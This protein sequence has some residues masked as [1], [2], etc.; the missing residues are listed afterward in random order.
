MKLYIKLTFTFF[1]IWGFSN[2][3][4]QTGNI[5]GTVIEKETRQPLAGANVIIIGTDLGASTDVNGKYEINNVPVDIYQIK[6]S[7]VGFESKIETD[8]VVKSNKTIFVNAELVAGSIEGEDIEV[9]STYFEK[10]DDSPISSQS[11]NKEEIRRSPGSREDVSRMLQ[12]FPG[13]NTS[14]DDRND[15]IIRGGSPTEVQFLL[16]NIEIPNPNHFGTQGAT[17]GPIGMINTEFIEKVNFYSGGFTAG[18][19]SKLSGVMDIKL[20]NGN[21][22]RWGGKIDLNFGGAGGY[23]EGPFANRKGSYLVGVHKSFLD[24]LKDALDMDGVPDYTNLQGKINYNFNNTH[25]LTLLWLG[26]D[27][28]IFFD[29]DVDADDFET[30]KI[31]TNYYDNTDFKTR[32]ITGGINLRSIWNNNLY[33]NLTASHTYSSFKLDVHGI[34]VIGINNSGE[35]ENKQEINYRLSFSNS[36]VEQITNLKFDANYIISQNSTL[37]LGGFIKRNMFDHNIKNIPPEPDE[38]DKY[39]QLP[40]SWD[41]NYSY[42]PVYKYGGYINLKF[43]LLNLININA[44]G[45]V[46]HFELIDE[47]SFSPRFTLLIDLTNKLSFHTGYGIYY[48]NPEFIWISSHESNKHNL[49]D[50][51]CDHYIAGLTYLVTPSLKLTLEGYLKRYFDYPVSSEEGYKMIS[52][53]NLGADYEASLE[54]RKLIS[55]GTGRA[56]GIDFMLQQ[57]MT[58][59]FYGLFSYSYSMTQHKALDGIYRPGA[60]DNRN[61]M[62]FIF[63]YQL[64]KENEFSIKF[65]Y[66]GGRPYTPFDKNKSIETGNGIL[67]LTS[68]NSERYDDYQ[69]LDL[70]YD[71]R[72]FYNWGTII[73]YVSVEN[74][75]NKKN[76]LVHRWDG[77]EHKTDYKYQTGL[78]FIGGF[79]LEF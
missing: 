30:G 74:I 52:M 7:F 51:R 13:V 59:S 8:V 71:K 60:F 4:A 76:V 32:Q 56:K 25:L 21:N 14:S 1:F 65:R 78:F 66:A 31:D 9:T 62:N 28:K 19:G 69:R 40:E 11:L 45:R 29:Y 46:N 18:Y 64:N 48:Q 36:S 57:K 70:R 49:K 44:G 35:L 5:F 38:V 42:N 15:L 2:L 77:D 43:T 27:D 37:T 6:F 41:I 54:T 10:P 61:V 55:S 53:A 73:W 17:G 22:D 33:T 3:Q 50:I 72:E 12:N 68:I 67:D 75:L 63:G 16:D 23:I 39:G 20:R 47:T 24:L 26:G 58:E 79:S 34:D